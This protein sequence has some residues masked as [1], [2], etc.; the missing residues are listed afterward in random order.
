M[1]AATVVEVRKDDLSKTRTTERPAAPLAPGAARLRIETFAITANN[2]T[3]GVVGERIGYWRFFPT[4]EDGWGV[5]PVWGVAT[6]EESAH[7]G[8]E[9]GERLYGYFPLAD[10]L[11]IEVAALKPGS[12]FD[13]AAHRADLPAVYNR[14]VRL[15]ADPAD[16]PAADAARTILQPLYFTGFCLYDFLL[17]ADWFGAS[18]I[19]IPSASSKTA[20]GTAYAI[21]GDEAAPKLIGVTSPGNE[22]AVRALGLYDEVVR[23]DDME[24]RID[25]GA[26]TAIVDMSGSGGVVGRLHRHLGDNMAYTSNVG[27]T[28]YDDA[29][30]GPDYI[31]ERSAMFFA[32]GHI[33]KRTEEWGPG[34]FDRRAAAFFAEAARRSMEWLQIRRAEGAAEAEAAWAEV[35]AGKT[36][37]EAA[38]AVRI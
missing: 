36:P 38:W 28:H 15:S 16:E 35:L 23:Y 22:A 30:M 2:V 17:A 18:Q 34:V 37:P 3:Y 11:T 14:Y 9:A 4:D 32:P 25:A 24:D 26:K 8:L 27:V 31:K 1:T 20:I 5:I 10:R 12:L 19:V 13:G 33:A 29:G 7:E 6:V 21:K